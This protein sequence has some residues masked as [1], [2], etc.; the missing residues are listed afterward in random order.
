MT[1][2]RAGALV[3]LT[4]A[5]AALAATA[6]L[7]VPAWFPAAGVSPQE[8]PKIE[9]DGRRIKARLF[10]VTEDGTRLTGVERDVAY[11]DSVEEQARQIISAQIAP[12]VEPQVSAIP[13]G[14]ELRALFVTPGGE[15]FVDMSVEM[16][17]AH[18]GGSLSELLTIYTIVNA[19]TANLPT[20]TAV[21]LLID[22]KEVD[23]LAGHVD[24]RSPLARS[25][26]W[27][28][29]AEASAAAPESQLSVRHPDQDTRNP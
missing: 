24:L 5:V 18:P 28:Q 8:A 19:L 20:V 1:V 7:S 23:T 10:Y 27:L 4:S 14:A 21:Q 2:R 9:S 3:L 11:A 17:A 15:A 25:L 12:A 16:A 22:G 26:A 13:Q 29:D 6:W